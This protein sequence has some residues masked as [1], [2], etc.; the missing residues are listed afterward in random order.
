MS[1]NEIEKSIREILHDQNITSH[2]V[3]ERV[4]IYEHKLF[5]N[6]E[7]DLRD[8][9]IIIKGRGY[10]K[11]TLRDLATNIIK[12]VDL[13]APLIFLVYTGSINDDAK[14]QFIKQCNRAK[15]LYCI[16]DTIDI[17]KL[18]VAYGKLPITK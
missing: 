9:G 17:T 4:D 13:P 1:E 12:A 11:I 15:K 16:L 6:N 5:V 18:L 8:V 10:P 2:G 7:S 14:N 3:V